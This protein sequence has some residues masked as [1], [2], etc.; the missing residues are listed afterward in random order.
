MLVY[1]HQGRNG[2][3]GNNG[4][5]VAVYENF[6]VPKVPTFSAQKSEK[7]LLGAI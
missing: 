3:R 7:E 6:V 5:L 4:A 2:G 1:V